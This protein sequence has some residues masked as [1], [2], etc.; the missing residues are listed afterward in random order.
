[1]W[2][3]RR[4]NSETDEWRAWWRER[5]E[6]ELRC[7]LMTA[8]DP[9]GVGD[10]PEAWDEYDEYAPQIARVLRET[11]DP[12]EAASRVAQY[13]HD[14]ERG[15]EMHSDQ[16][17]MANARLANS[18]VAWYGWSYTRSSTPAPARRS[19]RR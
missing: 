10:A 7:I 1:M 13:L 18:L 8:W 17:R 16:S 12:H 5:G 6:R 14:A 15:M 2:G 11:V 4:E 19:C 9:I 3:E